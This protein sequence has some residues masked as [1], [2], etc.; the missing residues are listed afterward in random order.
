MKNTGIG[1]HRGSRRSAARPAIVCIVVLAPLL[2][3]ELF[4]KIADIAKQNVT[5][6]LV[7][8][9]VAHA[10]EIADRGYILETGRTVLSGTGKELRESEYVQRSYLGT[11]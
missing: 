3:D 6:L 7:E 5:I 8:Q 11:G 4:A 1:V 2:V 10:L 9:K